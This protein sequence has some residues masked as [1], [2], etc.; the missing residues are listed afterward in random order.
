VRVGRGRVRIAARDAFARPG[1][2]ARA[3]RA[4]RLAHETG[5][6]AVW[7]VKQV[8]VC[9]GVGPRPR[10]RLLIARNRETGEVKYFVTNARPSVGLKRVLVAAFA[11]WHVE[12]AIRLAKS[13]VGLTHYEGRHYLGLR[14]HLVLCTLVLGFVAVHT[15]RLRGEKPGPDAGAGVPGAEREVRRA[16]PAAAGVG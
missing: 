14:R 11:R 9:L 15:E 13:E 1:A 3:A 6:D 7:Q 12:H 2:K 10:H 5:P 8:K 4:F 16:A